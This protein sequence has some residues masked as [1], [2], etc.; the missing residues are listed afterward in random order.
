MSKAWLFS[1]LATGMMAAG[2]GCHGPLVPPHAYHPYDSGFCNDC[3][4]YGHDAAG[5]VGGI[6]AALIFLFLRSGGGFGALRVRKPGDEDRA[7]RKNRR[8][9]G[10]EGKKAGTLN[11]LLEQINAMPDR[12]AALIL[13]LQH[14]LR[15]AATDNDLRLGRSETA[16]DIL[17]RLPAQWTH[18]AALRKLVMAEELVQFGGRA[19]AE[20]TF[21]ECLRTATPILRGAR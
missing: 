6:L 7:T 1:L 13:L 14:S 21:E 12:R 9:P 10:K 3:G 11:G 4:A 17:R 18:F 5:A 16:R 8:K 15:R 19:L 2:L 20:A